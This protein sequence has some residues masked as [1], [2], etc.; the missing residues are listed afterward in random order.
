MNS[1]YFQIFCNWTF[2]GFITKK[3]TDKEFGVH[4]G[5]KWRK[6]PVILDSSW[7]SC[8]PPPPFMVGRCSR[9]AILS[10]VS[11][12]GSTADAGGQGAEGCRVCWVSLGCCHREP[13]M[14]ERACGVVRIR[15]ETSELQWVHPW[16]H[17]RITWGPSNKHCCQDPTHHP[18]KQTDF[19]GGFQHHP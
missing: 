7:L 13:Q 18:L 6:L 2:K 9:L 1:L 19:R 17:L 8:L 5:N 10:H 14:Q 4:S 12:A 3:T 16:Q 11:W 15:R